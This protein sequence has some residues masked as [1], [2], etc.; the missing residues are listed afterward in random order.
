MAVEV[1]REDPPMCLL[2]GS[3]V[4]FTCVIMGFPRPRIIFW[5]G[6]QQV[7]PGEEGF[8]RVEMVDFDQVLCNFKD[9]CS[10]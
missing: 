4:I 5:Q 9:Q 1:D 7:V 8:T 2:E 10:L 3:S 6:P